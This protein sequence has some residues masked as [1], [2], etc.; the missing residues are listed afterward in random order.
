[1]PKRKDYTGQRFNRLVALKYLGRYKYFCQCD[2]GNTA[3]VFSINF[4]SGHTTSCGCAAVENA[5]K[6]CAQINADPD[7]SNNLAGFIAEVQADPTCH[8]A[9]DEQTQTAE[10]RAY[11]GARRRCTDPTGKWWKDYGGRGIEFRFKTFEE[12]LAAVGPK[13]EPHHLYSIDRFPNN[14]GHYE[15]GNVRWATR[16]EQNNNQRP[17]KR[18][19]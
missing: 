12:F 19:A 5:L 2:C 10:Y 17:R 18:A 6:N 1:M 15:P 3:E 14:D 9:Y 7:R 13:P 4:T 16:E 8:W 11:C